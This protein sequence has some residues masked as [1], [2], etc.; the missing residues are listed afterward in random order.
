MISRRATFWTQT[1][2]WT[3]CGLGGFF[4]FVLAPIRLSAGI[5]LVSTSALMVPVIFLIRFQTQKA[6]RK[7]AEF[8]SS[9]IQILQTMD[10]SPASR[11][12][13]CIARLWTQIAKPPAIEKIAEALNGEKSKPNCATIV[14]LGL[15]EIPAIGEQYFEPEIITPTAYFGAKL[16][17]VPIA[18]AILFFFLLQILGV[19]PKFVRNFGVFIYVVVIGLGV[20]FSW[21]RRT[22]VRPTYVRLAPGMIQVLEFRIRSGKPTIR[23]Y[24]MIG[25]T[26]AVVRMTLDQNKPRLVSLKLSREGHSDELPIDQMFDNARLADLTWKALLSTAATPTLPNDALAG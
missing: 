8:R 14:G 15:V 24:P 22:L 4:G 10:A 18:L 3:L 13:E 21:A 6:N 7:F 20:A 11:R 5:V 2:L 12:G 26:I 19:I 9:A 1:V 23:E 16:I 25:G 17:F